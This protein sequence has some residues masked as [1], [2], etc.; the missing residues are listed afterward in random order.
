M[1]LITIQ[2]P[3]FS[4]KMWIVENLNYVMNCKIIEI[5]LLSKS[6]YI[7]DIIRKT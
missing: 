3:E 4:N 6:Y 7:I 1:W 5:R 2:F